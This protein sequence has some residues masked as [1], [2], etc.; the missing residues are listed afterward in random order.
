M[1]NIGI[2]IFVLAKVVLALKQV[3]LIKHRHQKITIL[4]YYL[5]SFRFLR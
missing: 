3:S 1:E 5:I 2:E 4:Q